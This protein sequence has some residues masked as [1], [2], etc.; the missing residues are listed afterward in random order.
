M[1]KWGRGVFSLDEDILKLV[2]DVIRAIINDATT[3]MESF[4]NSQAI[5]SRTVISIRQS[6]VCE[7]KIESQEISFDRQ[8]MAVILH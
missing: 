4:V 6:V 5:H 1:G 7:P 3:T 2:T 8:W